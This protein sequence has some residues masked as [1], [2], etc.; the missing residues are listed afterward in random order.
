M[1]DMVWR[2]EMSEEQTVILDGKVYT[3]IRFMEMKEKIEKKPGVKLVE[4]K[5]GEFR[6]KIQG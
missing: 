3:K 2:L 4:V 1:T 5:P 6:T